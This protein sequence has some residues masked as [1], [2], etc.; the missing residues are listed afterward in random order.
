VAE[1]AASV[2]VGQ[3]GRRPAASHEPLIYD[4]SPDEGLGRAMIAWRLNAHVF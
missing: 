1:L 3:R 4:L 2:G